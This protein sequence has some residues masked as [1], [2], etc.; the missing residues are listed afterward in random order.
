[1]RS[2]DKDKDIKEKNPKDPKNSNEF[3]GAQY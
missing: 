3:A 1:M 2:I